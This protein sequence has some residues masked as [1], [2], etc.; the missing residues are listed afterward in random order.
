[1]T[2]DANRRSR[3]QAGYGQLNEPSVGKVVLQIKKIEKYVT[4]L[5]LDTYCG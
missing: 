2:E 4:I 5:A 1:M 3:H